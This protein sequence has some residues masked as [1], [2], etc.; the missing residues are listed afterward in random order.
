MIVAPCNFFNNV[1]LIFIIYQKNSNCLEQHI[2]MSHVQPCQNHDFA[3]FGYAK[4]DSFALVVFFGTPQFQ[5]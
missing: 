5:S 2:K 3:L 4:K 1:W